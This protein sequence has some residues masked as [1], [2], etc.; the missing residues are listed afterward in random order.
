MKHV[1]LAGD[2]IFD[3]QSYVKPNEPDVITQLNSLLDNGEKATL[4]AEDGAVTTSVSGQLEKIPEDATHLFISVGGN[5]AFEHLYLFDK[6]VSNI[7]D[8]FDQF[9][10]VMKDFEK[11]YIKMLTKA[12]KCCLKT[13]VCTIYHPCFDKGE[14][15]RIEDLL[16]LGLKLPQ[17]QKKAM[18]A[19]PIFNDIIFQEAVNFSLPI[20]DLRLIFNEN[21]DYA[22]PIEPSAI[23][24][25]KMTRILKKI[26]YEHDFLSK[27]TVIYK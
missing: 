18:T 19:L 27:K 25:I 15:D 5:D 24:G 23:G 13:T 7:G 21:T 14:S 20:M 16:T 17:L 22:N 9:Y 3:N 11:N 8:A 12:I 2:S 6:P 26:A 10:E 1:I 4:F